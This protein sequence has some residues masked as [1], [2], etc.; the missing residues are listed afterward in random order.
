MEIQ[1]TPVEEVIRE[2]EHQVEA[3]KREAGEK[4]RRNKK[5]KGIQTMFR[6]TLTNLVRL[7]ILADRKANLMISINAIII[8]ILVS[9][10]LRKVEG[11][12]YLLVP[13]LLLTFVCLFTIVF[14]LLSTRPS[15]KSKFVDHDNTPSTPPDLLF[16]ET[17]P[18]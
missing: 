1:S 17:S 5:S 8:S 4:K 14:A 7:S 15:L 2:L 3:L 18:S 6:T 11:V 12:N 10:I 13:T 16:L 9:Y